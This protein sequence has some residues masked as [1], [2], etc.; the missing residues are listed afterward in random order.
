M[1]HELGWQHK[2]NPFKI[3]WIK[4]FARGN[5]ILDLG[6]GQGWYSQ[7][8]WEQGM[9]VYAIDQA[10]GFSSSRYEPG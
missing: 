6:A 3:S 1:E 2:I 9:E 4:K 10:P 7:Y 8:L 5:R